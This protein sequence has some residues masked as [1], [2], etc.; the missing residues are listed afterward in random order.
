MR[1]LTTTR[2]GDG[3]QVYLSGIRRSLA[4]APAAI[5]RAMVII[6]LVCASEIASAEAWKGRPLADVLV[7]LRSNG[8]PLIY[9]SQ[10]VSPELRI[11]SEPNA[12]DP[13]DRLREVLK[14]LG[15]ALKP[16]GRAGEQMAIVRDEHT[17][18]ELVTTRSIVNSIH[19]DEIKVYA[20]R[21]DVQRDDSAESVAVAHSALERIT[22]SEQDAL[23]SLHYLPGTAS[24]GVSALT[25]VRGGN[26]DETLVRFD[27]IEL[28]NPVHLKDFQGLFGLLDGEFVQSLQ[29]FS[30]GY[31]ARF[32]NHTSGMVD[33]EAR[34]TSKNENLL[35]V[36]MLYTR[37]IS[38][39]SFSDDR[40]TWLFGYRNSSLPEVLSHLRRKIGDP[41]FEDFVG[42]VSYD[43]RGMKIIAGTLRLN[44]E[45]QLFTMS[46]NEQTVG[47]YHDTYFWLR[48]EQD[49]NDWL[50]SH[51]QLS[52]ATLDS[53]RSASV[54][55]PLINTGSLMRSR[56]SSVD[57]LLMDW[58]ASLGKSATLEWGARVDRGRLTY[59]YTS[60][61]S[62]LEPLA[63]TFFRL[64]RTTT[65]H[66]SGNPEGE[67]YSAYVSGHD[68][69]GPWTAELGLR[70]DDYDYIDNARLLSPRL[71]VRYTFD[72]DNNI[73]FSAGRFVQARS[74][75]A[76]DITS[77]APRFSTPESSRQFVLAFEH[78]FATQLL[79]HIEAYTKRN[80]HVRQYSENI[81]DVVTLAPELKIDY[82]VIPPQASY[83]KGV[84]LSLQSAQ[85]GPFNW[86]ANY[87]WSQAYD[88]IR[89]RNIPRSF[90]QPHALSAGLSWSS[91][92]W[93]NSA[94]L[95][96]HTGWPY[97][98]LQVK[99]T[100]GDDVATLG[101]R[102]SA[103]FGDFASLDLRTQ[104]QVPLGRTILQM[105]VEILNAF[106]RGN[107]C[108]RQLSVVEASDG[109]LQILV[110]QKSW[111]SLVPL[112][113][114]DY[115]F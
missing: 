50:T 62:P 6:A 112:A 115:R 98:P 26:E 66:L 4:F 42:R 38:S 27:G 5:V 10:V 11:A 108:C 45:L 95:S 107:D 75:T 114:I 51:V 34:H 63:A 22:G 13:V 29:F 96:W 74:P 78:R 52:R 84:E 15:L 2:T 19:L 17:S 40:G 31:P 25:H 35:G 104:Y 77:L 3:E 32:G 9:S 20:S 12:S 23:R 80:E 71:N 94:A 54:D 8:L 105:Y 93:Q 60:V 100:S 76:L 81:L 18:N 109:H 72:A 99:T 110:K 39:G 102:N 58:A 55:I 87:T 88:R 49:W 90:D 92:R 67:L 65:F 47:R 97:T 69:Y 36:S 70:W 111:L 28:Y 73:R 43:W 103:R 21:F 89:G 24:S 48:V 68:T 7:E 91:E 53:D 64:P 85:Q 59:D 37:A 101:P 113:G 14:P 30:G 41:Q 46:H 106:N 83:A 61:N 44:D 57:S 82:Q 79:F 16:V 86:W 33:I 56:D 1:A